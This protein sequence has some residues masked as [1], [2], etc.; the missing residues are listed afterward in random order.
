MPLEALRNGGVN[1]GTV[2]CKNGFP[3]AWNFNLVVTRIFGLINQI[4]LSSWRSLL[5]EPANDTPYL[6]RGSSYKV[7]A[8]DNEN[9]GFGD[10]L[11]IFKGTFYYAVISLGLLY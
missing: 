5:L 4:R 2:V 6:L 7:R 1:R 3:F 11:A 10:S 8:V 9:N